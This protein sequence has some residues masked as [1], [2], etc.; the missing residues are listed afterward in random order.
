M[1]IID[2]HTHAFPDALAERAVA[3]LTQK[4]MTAALD[5]KI[6]SLL[7]SMK[8]AGI[9][10]SVVCSIATKP[11][12][13]EKIFTWSQTVAS[14]RIIPLPSVHPAD[15]EAVNQI[16]RIQADGFI[17]LKLHPYYQEFLLDEPRLFPLY[18]AIRQCGL[19][20]VCH[21]GFDIAFPRE[22]RAEPARLQ[23]VMERFPDLRF[24]ATH[25]GAWED[26]E[27]VERHLIGKPV[28]ME[29]SFALTYLGAERT[30]RILL[31][32]PMDYLLFGTDSPWLGQAEELARLRA[33]HLPEPLMTRLLYD[34]AARLLGAG[35]SKIQ[36]H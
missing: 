3:E 29:T 17:G 21:T 5:G 35:A 8:A 27:D 31:A 32:H 1:A 9:E 23:R 28:F 13:F 26:W 16:H 33:L 34:N 14:P 2:F 30:R 20:L 7:A 25:L 4:G 22:R 10:R 12:Q 15:P 18:D 36:T 19:I 11:S 24:V 6:S